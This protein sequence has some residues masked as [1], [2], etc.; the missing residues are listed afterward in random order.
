LKFSPDQADGSTTCRADEVWRVTGPSKNYAS[1][2]DTMALTL[3]DPRIAPA[4]R[5]PLVKRIFGPMLNE[6]R[7]LVF[8]DLALRQS[9]VL[10]SLA[11]LMFWRFSW[12]I[13][14]GYLGLVFFYW[15]GPYVLMLHNTSHRRLFNRRYELFN[16]YIP[17]VLS[18]FFGGSPLSYFAHHVGMHH[19]E[20][21]RAT[22]SARPCASSAT[23]S[24]TSCA[25]SCAFSSALSS[26]CQ[27]TCGARN[28]TACCF[29]RWEG[30][31]P[32]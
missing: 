30:S 18:P 31:S 19:A 23:A 10:M 2:R 5:L 17:V 29:D 26:R 22:I 15:L 21:N 9:L 28:G 27:R 25:T 11:A 20:N 4:P 8:V 14:A 3:T 13:A 7:D 12:G 16:Y 6:E 1:P 32:R 24:S